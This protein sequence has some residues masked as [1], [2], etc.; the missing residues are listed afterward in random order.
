[1]AHGEFGGDGSVKWDISVDN[2]REGSPISVPN[3]KGHR[4]SGIDEVDEGQYFTISLEI[5]RNMNDK[6]SLANALQA[7]AQ[8]VSSMPA[9]SGIK[10]SL[11]LPIESDNP[12][13]IQIDWNSRP[14]TTVPAGGKPTAARK[15]A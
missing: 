6:T 5:P 15:K 12:D 13:Q 4:Q 14:L 10:V 3:G 1:M 8:T 11:P 7:A 9:G 2:V